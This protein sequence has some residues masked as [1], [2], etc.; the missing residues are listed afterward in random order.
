MEQNHHE[1]TNAN[2]Q[3][4]VVEAKERWNDLENLSSAVQ[5]EEKD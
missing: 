4:H 2:I 1:A 5:D 3:N